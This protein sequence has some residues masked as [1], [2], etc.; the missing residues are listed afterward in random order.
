MCTHIVGRP[1][2]IK[3]NY[4]VKIAWEEDYGIDLDHGMDLACWK[5]NSEISTE[6]SSLK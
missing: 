1:S 2:G 3:D 5:E 4:T 6:I